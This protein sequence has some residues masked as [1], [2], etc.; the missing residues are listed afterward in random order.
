MD[1]SFYFIDSV[2]Y[3]VAEIYTVGNRGLFFSFC[4]VGTRLIIC[5]SGCNFR[6]VDGLFFVVRVF[7]FRN[8]YLFR[9]IPCFFYEVALFE[10]NK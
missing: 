10:D 6:E 7:V 2:R 4:M 8:F 5:N 9:S 1:G 3:D